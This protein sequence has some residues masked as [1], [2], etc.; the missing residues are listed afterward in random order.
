MGRTHLWLLGI[1]QCLLLRFALRRW[2]FEILVQSL[3]T[4]PAKRPVTEFAWPI[5]FT[6]GCRSH[7]T[8]DPRSRVFP[9]GNPLHQNHHQELA[10]E[11][12]EVEG[13]LHVQIDG[14]RHH[15]FPFRVIA[16]LFSHLYIYI[17]TTFVDQTCTKKQ[18][19]MIFFFVTQA[20]HSE[21]RPTSSPPSTKVVAFSSLSSSPLSSPASDPPFS[22]GAATAGSAGR[23]GSSSFSESISLT[24]AWKFFGFAD[25]VRDYKV[26]CKHL[27]I[28]EAMVPADL[29]S[30]CV[31]IRM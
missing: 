29:F 31:Y 9:G 10:P 12:V 17:P 19:T 8:I 26:Q 22:A 21:T 25:L 3:P 5:H 15:H 1:T 24:N 16:R 28:C 13:H 18:E 11:L 4:R 14:H 27:I 7:I 23:S 30:M 20:S 6:W 2:R